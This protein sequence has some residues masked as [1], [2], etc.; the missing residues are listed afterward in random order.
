MIVWGMGLPFFLICRSCKR[1][2]CSFASLPRPVSS[3][4]G[5]KGCWAVPCA[6]TS[7]RNNIHIPSGQVMGEPIKTHKETYPNC[8]DQ[9][10]APVVGLFRPPSD[11]FSAGHYS[12][13][14]RFCRRFW[15]PW[16]LARRAVSISTV[17]CTSGHHCN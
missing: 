14:S 9:M 17:K 13:C 10:R 6:I 4:S 2:L 15:C 3:V 8:R 1:L 16:R 12:A 5:D 11:P 7:Y